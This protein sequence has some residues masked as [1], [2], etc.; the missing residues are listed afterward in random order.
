MHSSQSASSH[1]GQGAFIVTRKHQVPL[2][3]L[4]DPRA[5]INLFVGMQVALFV[6]VLIGIWVKSATSNEPYFAI[7]G[8]YLLF[9]W[10]PTA[11]V[12]ALVGTIMYRRAKR[13]CAARE[14]E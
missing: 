3:R 9:T 7:L 10:L 4:N 11:L 1:W 6:G 13:K 2:E 12:L 5:M 14:N 8:P